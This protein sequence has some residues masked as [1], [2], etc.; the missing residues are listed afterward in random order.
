MIG[1]LLHSLA[2]GIALG[3]SSIVSATSGHD[4]GEK[5]LDLIIFLAIMLH[6]APTAFALSTLLLSSVTSPSEQDSTKNSFIRTSLLLFSLSAPV[7]A[8]A[9]YI[10]LALFTN[11]ETELGWYTGMVLVF[12]GGSFLFVAVGGMSSSAPPAPPTTVATVH[13]RSSSRGGASTPSPAP[14]NLF[15]A[16][17]PSNPNS[18]SHLNTTFPSAQLHH[19]SPERAEGSVTERARLALVVLGMVTPSLL[20][21]VVGH[22][23]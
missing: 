8:L 12:S 11:G 13:S 6:K 22:G 19:D 17:G 15:P 21:K 10:L 14:T 16:Q 23:H 4:E 7:G 18:P 9:T 20:A 2:D 5:A 3:A 1:L